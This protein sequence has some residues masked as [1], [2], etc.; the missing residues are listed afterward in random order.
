M[1]CREII[2]LQCGSYA[3]RVAD[4]FW[5]IQDVYRKDNSSE[6]SVLYR[7]ANTIPVNCLTKIYD[8]ILYYY[9]V[10]WSLII[11]VE[12]WFFMFAISFVQYYLNVE[13]S[14]FT[15]HIMYLVKKYVCHDWIKIAIHSEIFS[16]I[17][18]MIVQQQCLT[19]ETLSYDK[20][21][22]PIK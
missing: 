16:L 9:A 6:A 2:T 19:F 8:V 5:D 21:T 14:L 10:I 13:L 11:P 4:Y 7:N 20:K 17:I 1:S 22:N 12:H 18:Q 3:S 15:T